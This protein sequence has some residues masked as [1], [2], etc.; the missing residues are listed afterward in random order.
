MSE[1][2]RAQ[3]GD[4]IWGGLYLS[5]GDDIDLD[6]ISPEQSFKQ[7]TADIEDYGTRDIGDE[8]HVMVERNDV[9][10]VLDTLTTV[11]QYFLQIG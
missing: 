1:V 4:I 6:G 2:L 11:K 5:N 3:I 10:Y 8:A 9:H 7:L